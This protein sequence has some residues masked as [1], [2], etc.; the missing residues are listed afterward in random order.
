MMLV[1]KAPLAVGDR[2]EVQATVGTRSVWIPIEVRHVSVEHGDRND[3][4]Y[5]VGAAFSPLTPADRASIVALF[6]GTTE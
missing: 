1:S 6:G 3:F 4:R 5:R 2:G